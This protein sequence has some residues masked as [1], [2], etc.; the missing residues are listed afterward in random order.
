MLFNKLLGAA[1]IGRLLFWFSFLTECSL[2]NLATQL[3][4]S[5]GKAKYKHRTS[6]SC[7]L[8]TETLTIS[9]TTLFNLDTILVSSHLHNANKCQAGVQWPLLKKQAARSDRNVEGPGRLKRNT[10]EVRTI[11][12]APT[13]LQKKSC[14]FMKPISDSNV[15]KFQ[16]LFVR[17]DTQNCRLENHFTC[18]FFVL[19][20]VVESPAEH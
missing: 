19:W 1:A 16:D 4:R 14:L 3:R 10:K 18:F 12:G 17:A 7:A 8:A 2:T 6:L 11:I 20:P 15:F 13:A 9:Q 5:F